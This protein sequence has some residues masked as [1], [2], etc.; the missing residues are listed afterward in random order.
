MLPEETMAHFVIDHCYLIIAMTMSFSFVSLRV[1]NV[2]TADCVWY[3]GLMILHCRLCFRNSLMPSKLCR[4]LTHLLISVCRRILT[5]HR[6]EP[7]AMPSFQ[8]WRS[9]SERTLVR[10]SLIAKSGRQNSTRFWH[11]GRNSTQLVCLLLFFVKISLDIS[12]II[13]RFWVFHTTSVSLIFSFVV[14]CQDFTCQ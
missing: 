7:P 2:S 5:D 12:V 11:C 8:S 9:W 1:K 10:P 6:R 3:I 4:S 13:I 14:L